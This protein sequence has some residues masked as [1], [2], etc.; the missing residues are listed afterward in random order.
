MIYIKWWFKM[1]YIN[2]HGLVCSFCLTCFGIGDESRSSRLGLVDLGCAVSLKQLETQRKED[3]NFDP[4]W[5]PKMVNLHFRWMFWFF[6]VDVSPTWKR[7]SAFQGTK[8]H[9]VKPFKGV[10]RDLERGTKTPRKGF[11]GNQ[12]LFRI[13]RHFGFYFGLSFGSLSLS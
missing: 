5:W 13:Y 3:F 7:C 1:I 4:R 6:L 9:A 11:P 8:I 2:H 12:H 10:R